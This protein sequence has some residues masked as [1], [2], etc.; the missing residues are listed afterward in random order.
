MIRSFVVSHKG[1]VQWQDSFWLSML[2]PK[3]SLLAVLGAHSRNTW[4]YTLSFLSFNYWTAPCICFDWINLL[5]CH[6]HLCSNQSLAALAQAAVTKYS[7]LGD[8]SNR[9][10][11]L[12]VLE[13]GK[14]KIKV[15]TDSVFGESPFPGLPSCCVLTW[16]FSGGVHVVREGS[17]LYSS[18]YKT[19]NPIMETTL[20]K[21][22][23]NLITLQRLCLQISSQW[24]VGLQHMNLGGEGTQ[25]FRS[26]H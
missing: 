20:S 17:C 3:V 12:T 18:T 1:H 4:G 13:A 14:S 5:L 25:T 21:P 9:D 7:R 19:T 22:T 24:G 15:S 26:Q 6:L 11:F 2:P 16:P 8:V 23:L 10:L